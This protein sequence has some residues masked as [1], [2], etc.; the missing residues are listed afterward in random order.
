MVVLR[1]VWVFPARYLLVRPTPDPTTGL[2][3]PW[4]Y[5]F[6]IGWAGMR[7]VVTLAA[8]FVI[9]EDTQYREILLLMA[10]TVVAGTL[11]VQ[12]MSLP[13]VAKRLAVPSPD[14]REDALARATLL[15][16]ATKASLEELD[17]IEHD[18]RH[19]VL[20]LIRQRVEQRNF[21]AWE[22]LGTVS[23]REA[24]SELYARA[25]VAMIGAERR[26]VLQIRDTGRVPSEVVAEV[27]AMLDVEESMLDVAT[28]QRRELLSGEATRSVRLSGDGCPDL[29]EHPSVR[30]ATAPVCEECLAAGLVWVALRQCLGC[31]HVACCDSS[32]Q[33]HATG[34]FHETGHRVM[35]SAEPGEDWRWCF[36]HHTTG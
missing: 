10:F 16:Q 22:R 20:E 24:P 3:P 26:R 1:L 11:F 23:E 19:G 7:G 15:Q 14:P 28:E 36:V 33:R 17:R 29:V 12:G 30:T 13:W 5:T 31:G 35:Q 4:S 18:D 6:L 21:A 9:P 32:P 8:A 34:H 2:T 27:L 25:R